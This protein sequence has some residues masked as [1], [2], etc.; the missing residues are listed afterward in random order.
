MRVVAEKLTPIDGLEGFRGAVFFIFDLQFLR[1]LILQKEKKSNN[2]T[3]I[4]S[5]ELF[6][7]NINFI[8]NIEINLILKF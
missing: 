8:P 6:H 5:N 2:D 7:V 3:K 1:V 4:S